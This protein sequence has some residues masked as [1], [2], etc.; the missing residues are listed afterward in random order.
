MLDNLNT[1]GRRAGGEGDTGR[2]LRA[3]VQKSHLSKSLSH[4]CHLDPGPPT[5][6]PKAGICTSLSP[7]ALSI[8]P[9]CAK[10]IR[11]GVCFLEVGVIY[12]EESR[13]VQSQL[14]S[15]PK[16]TFVLVMHTRKAPYNSHGQAKQP[17][18]D[19]WETTSS[20]MSWQRHT[21]QT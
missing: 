5:P 2:G 19:S 11:A 16:Y 20:Q 10:A 18:L 8:N 21:I 3:P 15:L 6:E 13:D 4:W 1:V 17:H 9:L 7:V 14:V 12:S